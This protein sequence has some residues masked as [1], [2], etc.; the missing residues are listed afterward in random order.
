M[1][2]MTNMFEIPT[3]ILQLKSL[4]LVLEQEQRA[5]LGKVPNI[6][7]NNCGREQFPHYSE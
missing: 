5:I 6:L 7:K 3:K 2:K 4:Q 1:S